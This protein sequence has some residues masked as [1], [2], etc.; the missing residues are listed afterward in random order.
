ML[1]KISRFGK[2]VLKVELIV[3]NDILMFFWVKYV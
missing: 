2:T 3:L 1:F